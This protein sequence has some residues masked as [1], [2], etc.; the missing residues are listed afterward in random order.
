MAELDVELGSLKFAR[1]V[2]DAWE[3]RG[4]RAALGQIALWLEERRGS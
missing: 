4:R 1:R 2:R 3:L